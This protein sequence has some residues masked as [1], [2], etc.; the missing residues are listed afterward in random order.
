MFGGREGE[1]CA[2]WFASFLNETK[3]KKIARFICKADK[4]CIGLEF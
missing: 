3:V 4:I 1:K 2:R